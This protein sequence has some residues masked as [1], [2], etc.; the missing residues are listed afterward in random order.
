MFLEKRVY[1]GLAAS[2][3]R[4]LIE[5]ISDEKTEQLYQCRFP[6]RTIIEDHDPA[7]AW[8]AS[9]AGYDKGPRRA[10]HLL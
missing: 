5:T 7:R 8:G 3:I 6:G 10:F 9:P 2:S 4:I 1:P